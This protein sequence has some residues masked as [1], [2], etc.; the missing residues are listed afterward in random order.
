MRNSIALGFCGLLAVAGSVWAAG[1]PAK[2]DEL[3]AEKGFIDDPIAISDD[4]STLA[5]LLTDGASFSEIHFGTIGSK[6]NRSTVA[7][8]SI[9]P[10]RMDFLDDQRLLV[11]ER[12][13]ETHFA[14][15]QIF[16][17]KGPTKDKLGPADDIVLATVGGQP[18]IVTYLRSEKGKAATHTLVAY[19]RSDMKQVAKK[20]LQENSDGKI[21]VAGA[22]MKLLFF[23]EG[24]AQMIAQKEGAYDSKHDIRKPDLEAQVDVFS[25]KVLLEREIKDLIKWAELAKLRRNHQNESDFVQFSEDLKQLMLT[26]REDVTTQISPT[27]PLGKYDTTTLRFQEMG[28]GALVFS[29]SIDPVNPEAVA[30]KKADQ[31]WLDLYKVDLTSHA[32]S[33]IGRIDGKK[34]T[35]KW[36]LM[37]SRIAVLRGHKGFARGGAEMEIFDLGGDLAPKKPAAPVKPADKATDKTPAK[38]PDK[39]PEKAPEKTPAKAPDKAAAPEKAADKTPAKTP[40]K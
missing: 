6:E 10:E 9:T 15:A 32:V 14:R 12:N 34:R 39:A 5:Y 1:A 29:L 26:D 20:V 38:G 36:R 3:S 11:V 8:P 23:E 4:G 25:G 22:A 31:D 28:G 40:S 30:A 7:Y 17:A 37:G 19:R 18:V 13:P 21:S 16:T 27:R 33:E 35:A 24:Y 2:L